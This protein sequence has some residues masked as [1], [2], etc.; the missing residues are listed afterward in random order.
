[1][2][3]ALW[4]IRTTRFN[5][6]NFSHNKETDVVTVSSRL[7]TG[8]KSPTTTSFCCGDNFVSEV[9]RHGEN[10]AFCFHNNVKSQR[11]TQKLFV[12]HFINIMNH[13]A[14]YQL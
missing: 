6:V 5:N 14:T 1:M 12:D 3:R 9:S 7:S 2:E 10:V 11:I 8:Y 4:L 13:S